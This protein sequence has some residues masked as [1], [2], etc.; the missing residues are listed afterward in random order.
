M[1]LEQIYFEQRKELKIELD[2]ND[3][4]CESQQDG[5]VNKF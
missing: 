3:Y 5:G 1:F 2:E 4:R